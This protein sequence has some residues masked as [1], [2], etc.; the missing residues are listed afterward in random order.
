MTAVLPHYKQGPENKQVSALT[1]GG[2]LVE[3]TTQSTP[4]TDFTVRPCVAGASAG[5][6]LLGVA[7]K[8]ANVIATQTG[9]PNTYGQAAID[10]S[11]LDDMTAVYYGGIDIWV[12]YAGQVVEGQLLMVNQTSG[13]GNN[14]TVVAFTGTTYSLIIGR[15]TANGGVPSASLT[16]QIGGLGSASYVLARARIF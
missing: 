11:V 6:N 7:A 10:I 4:T 1:F 3:P 12:W 14:G 15:C 2:Q 9:A 16:Q 8:D 5:L 13:A